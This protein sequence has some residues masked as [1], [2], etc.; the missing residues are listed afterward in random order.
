MDLLS[1]IEAAQGKKIKPINGK[2]RYGQTCAK[3]I[4]DFAAP[5]MPTNGSNSDI[6]TIYTI[7]MIAWNIALMP[8]DEQENF[9]ERTVDETE[10]GKHPKMIEH[11]YVMVERKKQ[12]FAQYDFQVADYQLQFLDNTSEIYLEVIGIDAPKKRN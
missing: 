11:I 9:I 1:Q 12:S 10:M 4:I 5:F 6:E 3:I 7:S 8:K 2:K